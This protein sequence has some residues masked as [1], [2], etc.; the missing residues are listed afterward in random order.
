LIESLATACFRF[1]PLIDLV[2]D[3]SKE[4][5]FRRLSSTNRQIVS[6]LRGGA[7]CEIDAADLVVGDVV[8]VR[9]GDVLPADGIFLTGSGLSCDES[10]MTGES[11]AVRKSAARPFLLAGTKVTEGTARMLVT[12]VGVSTEIGRT[13]V[14]IDE[15]AGD[16]QTPL[17]VK[18]E[19]MA[20]DIGKL[21][22]IA[23][24]LTVLVSMAWWL[25]DNLRAPSEE[26]WTHEQGI[27]VLEFF[28]L[29]VT[30]LVVAI[31]EGLPLAVTI[32][33]AYS[34][35]RMTKDNNLVRKLAACETMGGATQI[36]SDKTGT[37]TENRMTACAVWLAGTYHDTIPDR[38]RVARPVLE[39]VCDGIAINSSAYRAVDR[40]TGDAVYTGNKTESALLA[41][42]D[43]L[44]H[45]WAAR[46]ETLKGNPGYLS[47][48][49]SSTKK[50]M[51]T[52]ASLTGDPASRRLYAKGAPEILLSY[53][54]H[55]LVESGTAAP[56][57]GGPRGSQLV[58]LDDTSRNEVQQY[59]NRMASSGLRTML[60]ADRDFDR[61]TDDDFPPGDAPLDKLVLVAV[62]GIKDPLRPEVSAAVAKCKSAGIFVRMVTGDNMLTAKSIAREC[63]ILTDG[64][65]VE[66]PTFRAMPEAERQAILPRLQV[67]AR[68]SPTD[69]Y[70]LVDTLIKNG[71]VVAVTG[72]GTNDAAALARADVGLAMGIAGTQV[73]KDA[74]DVII[75]DD[76]FRSIVAAVKWGRSV[77]DN[78]RKFL[79]FQLTI[80]LVALTLV[81]VAACT[82]RETPLTPVQMLW[83]NLIMDT[84]A[85]LAL[86][87]EVPTEALLRRR[88]YGRHDRLV[89]RTMVRNIVGQAVLQLIILLVLLYAGADM[90]NIPE[91]SDLAALTDTE[92]ESDKLSQH[93]TIIFN[94]FV[95]LQLF[96]EVSS[97]KLHDDGPGVFEGL[98]A[99]PLFMSIIIGSAAFQAFI[100]EVGAGFTS[101][102]S[103][104]WDQWLICM[105]LG[106][107]SI[108][109]GYVVR[110]IPINESTVS[111]V[112]DGPTTYD[113]DGK[114]E[115][116]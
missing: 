8:D 53:C 21:G 51:A 20:V 7:L 25:D 11:D 59:V 17:E 77:Y 66:G 41:M 96:N 109:W 15:E 99:N 78:I 46:R 23:A 34:M 61:A 22:L 33:L 104:D 84:F 40:D 12:S 107:L 47:Y 44:G 60:M 35:T 89:S 38:A 2:N 87:T 76:N 3:W 43:A 54:T 1:P 55:M 74:A 52:V 105:A 13:R 50:S 63:G 101:T 42:C 106:F 32:S 29:G 28:V 18:L 113:E 81:F 95:F 91:G 27:R 30:I 97:R 111:P 39:R 115:G 68:S 36:C 5:Q 88:P 86:G 16:S 75:L 10:A 94:V 69:K 112:A 58:P 19:K 116:F 56:D 6:V 72:D 98:F 79:Q 65:A 45:D 103:L 48:P 90:F 70:L 93:Y 37:L 67:I 92:S 83:V 108:P 57:G 85:A 71:E 82:K 80:N 73:A 64:I 102:K 49:F 114:R 4:R 110:L 14:M 62:V 26:R 100:V 31:P 9:T 24:V